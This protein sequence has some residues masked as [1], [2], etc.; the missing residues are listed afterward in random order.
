MFDLSL[1]TVHGQGDVS[2]HIFACRPDDPGRD[3]VVRLEFYAQ[4]NAHKE[5]Y[6]NKSSHTFEIGFR[7][8]NLHDYQQPPLSMELEQVHIHLLPLVRRHFELQ[9]ILMNHAS[10]WELRI[11]SIDWR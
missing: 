4:A 5:S 8:T 1:G 7:I 6:L 10:K 2:G 11:G 9:M 3:G